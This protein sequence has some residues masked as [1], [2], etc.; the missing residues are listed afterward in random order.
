MCW[1]YFA[2]SVYNMANEDIEGHAKQHS[3]PM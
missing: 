2:K 1:F 3:K